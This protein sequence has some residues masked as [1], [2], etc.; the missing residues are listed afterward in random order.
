MQLDGC[1]C[2]WCGCCDKR[3]LLPCCF[4]GCNEVV[5]GSVIQSRGHVDAGA[6]IQRRIPHSLSQGSKKSGETRKFF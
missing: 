1:W 6:S 3:I 4:D 5:T 2:G